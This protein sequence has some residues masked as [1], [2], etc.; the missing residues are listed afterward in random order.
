MHKISINIRLPFAVQ[1]DEVVNPMNGNKYIKRVTQEYKDLTDYL[2]ENNIPFNSK[3]ADLD[4]NVFHKNI[5]I[6]NNVKY[7]N[8]K[9]LSV[10]LDKIFD[11]LKTQTP[12][13]HAF[14]LNDKWKKI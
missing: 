1:S 6:N 12:T 5:W 14:E 9:I 3:D 10:A 2:K 13:A 7:A 4:E 8:P 11:C